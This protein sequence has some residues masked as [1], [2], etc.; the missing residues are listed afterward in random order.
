VR[1]DVER[2]VWPL[3]EPFWVDW[4]EQQKIVDMLFASRLIARCHLMALVK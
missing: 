4:D 2:R 3:L 1:L